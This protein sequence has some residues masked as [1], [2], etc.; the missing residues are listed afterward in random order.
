MVS[1]GLKG[2]VVVSA[3]R[4]LLDAFRGEWRADPSL[5]RGFFLVVQTPPDSHLRN[6]SQ[7]SETSPRDILGRTRVESEHLKMSRRGGTTT[8]TAPP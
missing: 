7:V 5:A 6:E 8:T 1:V 2:T 4:G 3:W